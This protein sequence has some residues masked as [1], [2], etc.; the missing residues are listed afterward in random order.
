[1]RLRYVA[2]AA[3]CVGLLYAAPALAQ[4]AGGAPALDQIGQQFVTRFQ[5]IESTLRGFALRLFG[6]LVIIEFAWAAMGLAFRQADFG[7]WAAL[8]VNQIMFIGFGLALVTFGPAWAGAIVASFQQAGSQASAAAGGGAILHPSDVFGAGMNIAAKILEH[9]SALRPG[10]AIGFALCGVV[11]IVAFALICAIMIL[12]IVSGYAIV[13]MGVLFMGFSGSRWTRDL[14]MKVIMGVVGIGAKLMVL[15]IIVGVGASLFA[16]WSNKGI[17]TIDDAL[18]MVGF[19]VVMLALSKV[20][21]DLVGSMINGSVF[22]GGGALTA[23]GAAVA[24]GAAGFAAGMV[25]A[26]A[27]AHGAGKLASEQL[28]TASGQGKAPSSAMGRFMS[29]AGNTGRNLAGAAAQDVG[30]RLGGRA[31]Y[32]SMGGRMGDRMRTQAAEM[33]SAREA[34]TPAPAAASGGGNDNNTISAA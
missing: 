17:T 33:K 10:E 29:L 3:I 13:S 24:G 20:I 30:A 28:A 9:M 15:Q 23:A 5:S 4:T 25:G 2:G 22:T 19:S 1:M 31:P 12:T 7:E 27:A 16:D 21:P 26:G 8:L 6:L 14:A 32:G 18:V 11:V 34:P